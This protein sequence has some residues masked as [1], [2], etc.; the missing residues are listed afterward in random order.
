MAISLQ[1]QAFEFFQHIQQAWQSNTLQ[2]LI[3]SQY[4]GEEANLQKLMIRPIT[5]KDELQLQV[6]YRYQTKDITKNYT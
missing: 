2:R 5:L 1:G 3:F 6:V 4:Q